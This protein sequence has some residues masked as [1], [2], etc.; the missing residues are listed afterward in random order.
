[1]FATNPIRQYPLLRWMGVA[2]C[3]PAHLL[4]GN[5]RMNSLLNLVLFLPAGGAILVLLLP[6]NDLRKIRLTALI[7]ALLTFALSVPLAI[8]FRIDTSEMQFATDVRW[9][10]APPIRY[11]IGIDGISLFLVLLIALLTIFCVLISWR[12]VASRAKE[13]FFFLLLLE[14]GTIGVFVAI[15][16]F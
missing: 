2:R 15:D 9:M 7:I 13:F 1:H 3:G 16:L 8:R 10:D 11:H 5:G 14:T 12:S 6:R 4:H